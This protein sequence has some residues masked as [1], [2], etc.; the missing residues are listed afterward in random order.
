M[1]S[2]LELSQKLKDEQDAVRNLR[3]E[4][5]RERNLKILTENDLQVKHRQLQEEY[6]SLA[7]QVRSFQ[8][9]LQAGHKTSLQCAE[10]LGK[11]TRERK[12]LEDKLG[13][14]LEMLEDYSLKLKEGRKQLQWFQA[15][16]TS[17]EKKLVAARGQL[18]EANARAASAEAA[19][20]T[21]E[22]K[23]HNVHVD[24]QNQ[25]LDLEDMKEKLMAQQNELERERSM[26]E[27]LEKR[28]NRGS[29]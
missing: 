10:D 17:E 8:L 13:K 22:A 24:W 25:F 18:Q 3:G 14:T 7:K 19:L 16:A 6:E 21:V 26:R 29:T 11:E 20:S 9:Q 4:L 23:L 2:N 28:F 5:K 27:D 15:N 12:L 1:Q